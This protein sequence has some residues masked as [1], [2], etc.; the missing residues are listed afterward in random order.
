VVDALVE[1]GLARRADDPADRRIC[2]V[3]ITAKGRSLVGRVKRG[4]VDE[5]E[6]VLRNVPPASREAVIQA[7]TDLLGAYEKRCGQESECGQIAQR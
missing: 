5:Y 7:V 3:Q 2:R 4:L 6:Q 1:G